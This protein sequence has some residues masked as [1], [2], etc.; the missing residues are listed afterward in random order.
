[1]LQLQPNNLLIHTTLTERLDPAAVP[2]AIDRI[3]T[4]YDFT[5]YHISNLENKSQ[6]LVSMSIKCFPDLRKYGVDGVMAREYGAYVTTPEAGYDVSL[7]LDLETTSALSDAVRA[8]LVEKVSYFKRNAMAAAFE[9]AFERFD[10]LSQE[11]VAKQVDLYAPENTSDEEILVLNYRD[12]EQ[13][14][15]RPSFDRVTV[16]FSTIFKDE[17]DKIFG[18]VFLQEFVDARKRAVQNAPQVLY[19]HKEPP[20]EL[21]R[22]GVKQEEN[23]GFITFVLFPRH[24]APTRRENC[25]T[26]IQF[27]RNYFHYHIKCSK[28][29]M[30]SRMRFRVSEFLK[31]LNRA[32]PENLE[33]ERKT[34]TGRRFEH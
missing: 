2:L 14:F 9:R 29:Y 25:I 10:V 8:E 12:D 20:L 4:D 31:V 13:I 28:A 32:K 6:I 5:T 16:I 21:S 15:I 17:T 26:H 3:V 34:A 1:M 30:H 18:K 7:L 33:V 19:S 22:L 11:S 27:F 24:L 23:K